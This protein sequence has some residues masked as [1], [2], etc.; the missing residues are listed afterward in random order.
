MLTKAESV[1]KFIFFEKEILYK[2]YT[3]RKNIITAFV[4]GLV[5]STLFAFT[6][7]Y[8]AKNNTAEVDQLEGV[9]FFANSKPVKEYEYL[10]S[11]KIGFTM[12]NGGYQDMR[13][14]LVKKAKKEYPKA[15]GIIYNGDDKA[16]CIKFK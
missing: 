1:E 5:L 7:V 8:E 4:C 6:A 12:G 10:G 11:V 14:K 3:M 2:P 16:D 9:Y 15:D 13:E